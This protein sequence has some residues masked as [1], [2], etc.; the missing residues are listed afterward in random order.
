MKDHD[1]AHFLVPDMLDGETI[2]FRSG[3]LGGFSVVGTV[4]CLRGATTSSTPPSA[5]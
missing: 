5:P 3:G 1:D 2:L 4:T